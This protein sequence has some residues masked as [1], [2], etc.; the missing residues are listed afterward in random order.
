[1]PSTSNIETDS[2]QRHGLAPMKILKRY[3]HIAIE[4]D[5]KVVLAYCY[6]IDVFLSLLYYRCVHVQEKLESSHS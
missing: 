3:Q 4:Y 2:V 1:L 5:Y 6:I